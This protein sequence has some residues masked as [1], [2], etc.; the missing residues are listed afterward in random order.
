MKKLL[1]N[2][3]LASLLLCAGMPALS[4][5]DGW[6]NS[7]RTKFL[8]N[9]AVIMEIN[10]RSFNADDKNG[11][12]FIQEELGEKRGTFVNAVER[13][14]ELKNLGINTLHVLPVTPTGKLKALGTA[15]S[16]Y[17]AAAFD[18]I[19]EDLYDKNSKLTLEEQAK[20]FIEEAHKRGISVIVDVPACGSYD[21]FMERPDLFVTTPSGEPVIPSDWTDVRLLSV[22][23]E[24]KID[25]NTYSLY[26]DFVKFMMKL[27]VDGIRA[28]VAHSKTAAFWKE[29]IEYSREKDEQFLW[30]AESSESWHDAISPQAPFTS[31]DKLL[32]AGFDGYYGSFFNL[33]NWTNSKQLYK[34]FDYT[35]SE[36]KKFKE[37]KSI[38]GAFTTHD[39]VSPVLLKGEDF[40]NMIIWLN[41]T[42]PVN[43]YYV[44]G[45]QTGDEYYYKKG[46]RHAEYSLTDDD[47]YFIHNG[48]IDIFNLSRRPGGNNKEIKNNFIL[49]NN[50]KKSVLPVLNGGDFT[51][52]KTNNQKVFGYMF[53]DGTKKVVTVGNLDFEKSQ[54]VTVKIPKLNA[55]RQKLLPIKIT[56]MPDTRNGRMVLDMKAGEVVVVIINSAK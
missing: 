44:D 19:N 37:P 30:L 9:E 4:S 1:K 41:S 48:Q 34:Q 22:G 55:K 40:S 24:D 42:L 26:K 50:I 51:P 46:N 8:N 13:L 18:T 56:T 31:Y 33:K 17:S 11:D 39:E 36:T 49:G 38:I 21:L 6:K 7:L 29:L 14:D 16:L 54:K 35:F 25:P 32:E 12:G 27:G 15:G 10:I 20:N 47:T 23:T 3:L 53:A 5:D 2:V 43:S 28:D 45:F 52:L